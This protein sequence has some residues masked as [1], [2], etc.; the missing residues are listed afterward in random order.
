[1]TVVF[2]WMDGF[3]HGLRTGADTGLARAGHRT[4]DLAM[5]PGRSAGRVV[6]APLRPTSGAPG[7]PGCT[8]AK[9]CRAAAETPFLSRG[10]A[11]LDIGPE[12]LA[13]AEGGDSGAL[14]G[15]AGHAP[16][17]AGRMRDEEPI[18]R[19]SRKKGL[20]P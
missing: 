13:V 7:A 2:L 15:L 6:H 9:R 18:S 17:S 14:H 12:P 19:S 16:C 4:G 3:A 1:M 8:A 10:C 20:L 5:Q 11:P